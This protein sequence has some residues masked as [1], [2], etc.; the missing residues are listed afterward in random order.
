VACGFWFLVF[1]L[2]FAI[3]VDVCSRVWC[4]VLSCIMPGLVDFVTDSYGH[5]VF[6]QGIGEFF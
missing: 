2:W 4:V 3:R 5:A 6:A 1:G